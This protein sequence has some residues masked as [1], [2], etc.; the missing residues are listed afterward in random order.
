ATAGGPG[1]ARRVGA[2]PPGAA[3][4]PRR[5]LRVGGVS[6]GARGAQYRGG[7]SA[8]GAATGRSAARDV[9]RGGASRPAGAGGGRPRGRTGVRARVVCGTAGDVQPGGGVG[10]DDGAGDDLLSGA[11]GAPEPPA[12]SE[13]PHHEPGPLPLIP[14]FCL[15]TNRAAPAHAP[16]TSTS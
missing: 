8:A 16:T 6:A 10:A 4:E 11:A 2:D 9:E 5:A 14:S 7:R 1:A 13:G 12:R 3:R 15:Y